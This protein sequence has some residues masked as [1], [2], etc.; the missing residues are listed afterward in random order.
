[1]Y[2]VEGLCEIRYFYTPFRINELGPLLEGY[3][4]RYQNG[5]AHTVLVQQDYSRN[6]SYRKSQN[7]IKITSQKY[8]LLMAKTGNSVSVHP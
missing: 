4:S 6:L 5:N 8:L 1:M 7:Y 2:K 3:F